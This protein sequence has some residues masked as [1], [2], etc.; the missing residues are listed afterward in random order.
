MR[1]VGRSILLI[2]GAYLLLILLVFLLGRYVVDF[3]G[4]FA[5]VIEKL[6]DRFVLLL[7]L[8]SE[9]F[10]GMVPVDLFVIWTRKFEHPLP[11]LALLGLISYSG[12]VISYGIGKWI[13]GRPAFRSY[14]ER[15]LQSYMGF[16]R[17]WG[18]AFIII[19]A[20]FPFTPFSLVV[21]ALALLRYPFRL[22]LIFALARLFRFV[23]QVVFFF[24]LLKVQNWITAA[25]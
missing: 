13:S 15:R 25:F 16:A 5:A 1:Y 14:A 9:S 20:L 10:T 7:F 11:F 23:L 18:G 22:F 12:G 19:A 21:I 8:L 4:F 24:D 3:R 17:K 6:S 2:L